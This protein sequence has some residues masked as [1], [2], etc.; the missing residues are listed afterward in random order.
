MRIEQPDPKA[1]AGTCSESL[2]T[3]G[4][5]GWT[6]REQ[7]LHTNQLTHVI[8][9]GKMPMLFLTDCAASAP[10]L[11]LRFVVC[12]YRRCL[13]QGGGEGVQ[14]GVAVQWHVV[15]AQV[16][17]QALVELARGGGDGGKVAGL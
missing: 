1:T 9:V 12:G 16:G 8:P 14:I 4:L 11:H 17:L 3:D 2:W 6:G 7:T 13:F 15:G 10:L 5:D